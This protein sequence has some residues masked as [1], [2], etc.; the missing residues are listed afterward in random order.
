MKIGPLEI[1]DSAVLA[2]M[3][4]VTDLAF[5]KIVRELGCGLCYT[6]FVSADGIVRGGDGSFRLLR[7]EPWDRP[8]GVQIFGSD[9]AILAEAARIAVEKTGCDVLDLNMGCWVPK[10]VRRGAGAALLKNPAHVEK[11]V[12][13]VVDAVRVPVTAKIRAGFSADSINHV[14]VGRA[15]EAGGAKAVTLHAR[16]RAQ[17]HNGAPM[18]DLIGELKQAVSIPVIGNG[19]VL[20]AGDVLAMKRQ[21]GCDAVMIARAALP[22][23]WIFRQ[24]AEL[25]AGRPAWIPSGAERME[26]VRRHIDYAV[27][28]NEGW[29]TK[30]S[31]K[32]GLDH[33][34]HAVLKL[35][36]MFVAY[37]NGIPGAAEFRRTLN[38]LDSVEAALAGLAKVFERADEWQPPRG[39]AE[40][41]EDGDEACNAA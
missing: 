13:A 8:L 18:W 27:S 32:R 2:P 38:G 16:V 28:M 10:V 1:G 21:T 29:E 11:I 4:G 9:P 37:T 3:A 22:Q 5:R 14:E 41:V 24:V 23:P 30:R 25:E 20:T 7:T 19:G 12:R 40:S 33:A 17:A 15:I 6:E 31:K 35:R 39:F 36:G 34:Q 26:I